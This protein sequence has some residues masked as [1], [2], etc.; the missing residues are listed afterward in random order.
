MWSKSRNRTSV[1]GS[2]NLE[3]NH[4][5]TFRYAFMDSE[6]DRPVSLSRK[7]VLDLLALHLL[8]QRPECGADNFV[9]GVAYSRNDGPAIFADECRRI[10]DRSHRAFELDAIS[11]AWDR[12]PR[13]WWE[14]PV[15]AVRSNGAPQRPVRF[16][17]LSADDRKVGCGGSQPTLS[18]AVAAGSVMA[19]C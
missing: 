4:G 14:K 3:N 17:R 19:G 15:E 5:L 18:A 6:I 2:W 7:P 9:V 10:R 11:P 1:C 13:Q 8:T 12:I 16:Y